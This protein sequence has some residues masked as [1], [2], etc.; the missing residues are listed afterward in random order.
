MVSLLLLYSHGSISTGLGYQTFVTRLSF[1]L[2]QISALDRDRHV[3]VGVA[4]L[5]FGSGLSR[6]ELVVDQLLTLDYHA[7]LLGLGFYEGKV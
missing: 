1:I 6:C 3:I 4:A 2:S 7:F 5:E